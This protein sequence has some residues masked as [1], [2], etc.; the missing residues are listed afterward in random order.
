LKPKNLLLLRANVFQ[1]IS[2]QPIA[3][4]GIARIHPPNF[5]KR[6]NKRA[7]ELQSVFTSDLDSILNDP[8]IT[9]VIVCSET[10]HRRELVTRAA[11]AGK[12]MFVKARYY[13]TKLEGANGGEWTDLPA[14]ASHAFELF[15]DK[16]EGR[17]ISVDL[18]SAK[19]SRVMAAMYSA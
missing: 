6:I 4:L 8:E 16:L 1:E 2:L 10:S 7:S 14:A 3:L 18:I 15:W 17:E 12:H 9:S 13:S 5:I 11:A 19:E